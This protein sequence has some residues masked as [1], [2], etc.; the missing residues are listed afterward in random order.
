MEP[1]E[2]PTW[3]LFVDASSEQIG[4]GAGVVLESLEGHKLNCAIRLGFKASNNAAEYEVNGKFAAK[5]SSMA[6][7]LKLVLNLVSHFERFE[8]IHVPHLKNT[9]A[10]ALSKLASSKDS[11]LLK[12]GPIERLPKP[13]ISGGEEVCWIEGT[14][15]WMQPIIVYLR[16]QLVPA[17]KNKAKKLRRKAIHFIFQDDVL[18]KRGFAS[19]F[20]RCMRGEETIY[21]LREIHEEVCGTHSRGTALAHKPLVV[22]KWGID[23]IGP[24][25]K[26]RGSA[27][28]DV[29]AIDYF[30]KCDMTQESSLTKASTK[31]DPLIVDGGP[32]MRSK[33]KRVNEAMDLIQ[34]FELVLGGVKEKV[35]RQGEWMAQ[36]GTIITN[37]SREQ[38]EMSNVRGSCRRFIVN[39]ATRFASKW[40]GAKPL[41]KFTEVNTTKFV[42]KHII[43]KV[44]IPYSLVSDNRRQFNNRKMQDLYDEL[45]IRKDFSTPHHPQ[46][47]GRVKAVNKMIKYTLKRKLDAS[48]RAW[49]DE[50]PYVLWA[51]CRTSQ[52]A[53]EKTPF[54]MT[55]RSKAMSLVEVGVPSYRRIHFNKVSNDEAR[56]CELHLLEE[57]RDIS[58]VKLAIYQRKITPYY[59]SKVKNRTL[60]LGDLA[61]RRVFPSSKQTSSRVL[62]SNWEGPYRIVKKSRP[63]TYEIED[64]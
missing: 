41:A 46:A 61:L 34:R 20:L 44:D 10:D 60:R 63:K 30:T 37:L 8:L 7:Y 5:D 54:S 28:F 6:A 3:N 21:I 57:K 36:I 53:T 26:R 40:V 50:L 1:A 14:P 62:G 55:Y 51:I 16:D 45:G 42:W 12:I 19:P 48:K 9:H 64:I 11:E 29:V 39:V 4:S 15:L 32:M 24:L 18:Y 35:D 38:V 56:V 58:Q 49:V 23:L 31:R 17:S 47:N 22:H 27:T 25:P 52:T 59:N 33:M 13:S 2:L 43:C